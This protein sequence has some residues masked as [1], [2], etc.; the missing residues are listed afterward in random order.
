MSRQDCLALTVA[1]RPCPNREKDPGSVFCGK[2]KTSLPKKA[3]CQDKTYTGRPC[4]NFEKT[5]GSK[6]CGKHGKPK[7]HV[8]NSTRINTTIKF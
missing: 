7:I 3:L 6:F 4:P 1:G 5:R 8:L 2:H